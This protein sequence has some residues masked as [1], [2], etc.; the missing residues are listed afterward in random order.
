MK[1]KMP[2]LS[3]KNRKGGRGA[4][5]SFRSSGLDFRR[6]VPSQCGSSCVCVW[7]RVN[8]RCPHMKVPH[9]RG[10]CETSARR[11]SAGRFGRL[12]SSAQ[13]GGRVGV[14]FFSPAPSLPASLLLASSSPTA[15]SCALSWGRR[16]WGVGWGRWPVT[17]G[18][19]GAGCG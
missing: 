5:N 10:R 11:P 12:K 2:P 6:S 4:R 18:Y 15:Q 17:D 13:L 16:A 9:K 1:T 19:R 14:F 7:V 3:K 8:V